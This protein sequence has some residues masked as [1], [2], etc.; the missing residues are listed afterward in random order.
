MYSSI[1]SSASALD[2]VGGRRHTPVASPLGKRPD[3]HHTGGSVGPR[4][5]TDGR[6]K[7]R[8]PTGIRSTDR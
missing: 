2:G 7:S 6:G 5:V 4:T 8:P 1:L 3:T